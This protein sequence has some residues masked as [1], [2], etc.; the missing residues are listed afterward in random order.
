[1]RA[2][3]PIEHFDAFK[4]AVESQGGLAEKLIAVTRRP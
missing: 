1:V 3:L 2:K 4:A